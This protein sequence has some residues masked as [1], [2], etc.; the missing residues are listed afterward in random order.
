MYKEENEWTLK[1]K[2][3]LGIAIFMVL[4]FL[5]TSFFG[6]RGIVE[7]FKYKDEIA[8]LEKEVAILKK[9]KKKL[10]VEVKELEKNSMAVEPIARKDL[11]YKKKGEIVIVFKGK[12]SNSE[13]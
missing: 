4:T 12:E 11:W 2:I 9:E 1:K 5:I 6:R 10:E 13:K 8:Q 3:I 7:I